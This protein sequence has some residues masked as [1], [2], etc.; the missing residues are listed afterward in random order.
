M[1]TTLLS[2]IGLLAT[3][4]EA[5]GEIAD[6]ALVMDGEHVVWVGSAASATVSVPVGGAAKAGAAMNARASI[7][8]APP[9]G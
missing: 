4:D 1:S 8:T 2:G 7:M 6:A 5:L 3:Q 9:T